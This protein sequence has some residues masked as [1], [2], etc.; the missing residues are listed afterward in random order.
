MERN[1][2]KIKRTAGGFESSSDLTNETS[3]I[4]EPYYGRVKTTLANPLLRLDHDTAK[5]HSMV[6]K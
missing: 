2:G 6:G 1:S 3:D 4:W 5:V